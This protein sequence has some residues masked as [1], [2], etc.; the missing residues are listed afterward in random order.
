M[1]AFVTLH[2]VIYLLEIRETEHPPDKERAS[3]N[4]SLMKYLKHTGLANKSTKLNLNLPQ[5]CW[6]ITSHY[7]ARGITYQY[8]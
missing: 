2:L 4:N 3:S 8:A 6:S 7:G 5:S 1:L